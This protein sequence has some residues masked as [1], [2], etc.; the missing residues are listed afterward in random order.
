MRVKPIIGIGLAA[1][2]A[3]LAALLVFVWTYDVDRLKPHIQ[4]WVREATGRELAING[5]MHLSPGWNPRLVVKDVTF[6][7]ATWGTQPE[8]ARIEEL[9]VGVA[10]F[11]LIAGR[12]EVKNLTLVRPDILIETDREGTSNLHMTP[13]GGRREKGETAKAVFPLPDFRNLRLVDGSLSFRDGR[14]GASHP[15]RMDALTLT[16]EAFG[17]PSR[18]QMQGEYRGAPFEIGGTIGSFAGILEPSVVWPLK[19][20]G[21]ASGAEFSIEG[22]IK[23]PIRLTGVALAISVQAAISDV[24][25]GGKQELSEAGG[26]YRVFC[27]MTDTGPG[28]WRFSDLEMTGDENRV[29]GQMTLNLGRRKPHIQAELAGRRL[30]LRPF[31]ALWEPPM[32][33]KE[34]PPVA[35]KQK[36]K[37]FPNTPLGLNRLNAVDVSAAFQMDS[38]LLPNLALDRV[39]GNVVLTDGRLQIKS[40]KAHAGGGDMAADV[41]IDA[42]GRNPTISTKATITRLN[43]GSMLKEAGIQSPIEGSVDTELDLA[44]RGDSVAEWMAGLNGA[45]VFDMSHARIVGSYMDRLPG[46]LGTGLLLLLNPLKKKEETIAINCL[47]SDFRIKDGLAKSNVLFLD[48]AS[49][50]AAGAGWV[51]LKTEELR[52]GIKPKAKQGIGTKETG[53]L[54]VGLSELARPFELTGTLTHPTLTISTTDAILTIAKAAGGVALFGPVGL[55]SLFISGDFGEIDSCA[56]ARKAVSQPAGKEK[57]GTT[58]VQNGSSLEEGVGK[59]VDTI[60][61]LFGN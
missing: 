38:L 23:D 3:L 32:A 60:K 31:M 36:G 39:E 43:L 30:D 61:G 1:M 14:T 28:E 6:Q 34:E 45:A 35:P 12:L 48:T 52:F 37:A 13:A 41:E 10:L 2:S 44:G 4:K 55:A 20:K 49:L 7:N 47:V 56:S 11:P 5:R 9:D 57:K 46:D 25:R 53:R 40:L 18:I 15:L 27:R 54:T 21:T 8:M 17:E 22:Q 33:G 29:S 50:T 16:S 42:T 24:W 51:N 26:I 19:V 59:V 58:D